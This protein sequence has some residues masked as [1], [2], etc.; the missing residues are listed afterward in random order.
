ML[1]L[2]CL[3]TQCS[4]PARGRPGS[5]PRSQRAAGAAENGGGALAVEGRRRRLIVAAKRRQP[6]HQRCLNI[7]TTTVHLA[8][9]GRSNMSQQQ[10]QQR[11]VAT[12]SFEYC[13]GHDS[14]PRTGRDVLK[15]GGEDRVSVFPA[16]GA[17]LRVNQFASLLKHPCKSTVLTLVS[18]EVCCQSGL[19]YGYEVWTAGWT[20][21]T[22]CR[23]S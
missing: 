13:G 11:H 22:T 1:L 10:R 15:H 18:R 23:W 4:H 17:E 2:E 3:R 16:D 9:N 21:Q 12:T 20:K 5:K 14:A 6:M 8:S 7:A 19:T